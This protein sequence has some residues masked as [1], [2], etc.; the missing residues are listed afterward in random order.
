MIIS[1]ACRATVNGEK[2]IIPCHRHSNFYEIMKVL[3]CQYDK[4]SV[5]QGFIDWDELEQKGEFVSRVEAAK[6]AEK[7]NQI[8]PR[9]R[10]EFNPNCLYSEDIY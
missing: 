6:I 3:H 9:M 7:C 2:V 5:E 4:A 10:E 8:L 1:A